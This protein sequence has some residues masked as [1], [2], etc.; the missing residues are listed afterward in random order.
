MWPELPV[1]ERMRRKFLMDA[2]DEKHV[3]AVAPVITEP[4]HEIALSELCKQGTSDREWAY[5]FCASKPGYHPRYRV[6]E[7]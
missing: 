6:Q 1:Q 3:V 5:G 2:D 7:R 4:G